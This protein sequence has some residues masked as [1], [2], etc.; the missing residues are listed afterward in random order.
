VKVAIQIFFI[1]L[2]P[3]F[4]FGQDFK[5]SVSGSVTDRKTGEPLTDVNIRSSNNNTGTITNESGDFA[6][7]LSIFPTSL[8]F[9]HIGYSS[10]K[11]NL[12]APPIGKI[13][14]Q[15]TPEVTKLSGVTVITDRIDTIYRDKKYSVLDYEL[16]D[17][18]ILLLIFK[19]TLSRAELLFRTYDGEDKAKLTILPGRP[20][21]LFRDCLG[22]VHLFTKTRS[23]QIYFEGDNI[24]LMPGVNIDDFK[25]VMG[26]CKF[27]AGNHLYFEKR[28]FYDL[29][30]KYYSADT[31]SKDWTLFRTIFDKDK[32]AFLDRNAIAVPEKNLILINGI[33]GDRD[34]STW[35]E[36]RNIEVQNRFTKMVY[37]APVYAPMQRFGDTIC[38]FNH[39]DSVIEFYD[40]SN[41][42][43]FTTPIKYHVT[44][45]YD[46]LRTFASVWAKS[47]KW[48]K[49]VIIDEQ[50]RKLYTLFIRNNGQKELREISIKTGETSLVMKIPFSYV[51][52]I[53]VRDGYAYFIYKGWIETEKKKLFR[54]RID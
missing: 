43:L 20:F 15:L 34:G 6:I 31:A 3:L 8:I 25:D 11:V 23:F 44:K 33:P 39:P 7:S 26:D 52:K 4:I 2:C 51:E 27:R 53:K 5:F 48:D 41:T 12:E 28:I 19:Y 22:N 45:K 40:L 21:Q 17:D 54:Q 1:L 18:G 37:L 29:I 32:M 38:I 16:L 30:L 35:R 46:P 49:S 14:V 42:L 24:K 47:V 9:T 36:Y 13:N 50:K 10:L